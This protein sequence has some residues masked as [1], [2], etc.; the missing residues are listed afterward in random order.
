M[1][2]RKNIRFP[3]DAGDV[4]YLDRSVASDK[5]T[6]DI[7]GLILNESHR[8]CALIVVAS[9]AELAPSTEVRVRV[10]RQAVLAATVA[11]ID[12]IDPGVYK[13]GLNYCA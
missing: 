12:A 8:G 1:A 11:W 9:E 5:F 7:A 6:P 2:Q 10:G 3:P 4:A 13:V